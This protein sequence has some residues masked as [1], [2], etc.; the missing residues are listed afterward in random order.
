MTSRPS[1][2]NKVAGF[3]VFP[4][5]VDEKTIE[6][7]SIY[8]LPSV[9]ASESQSDSE[10]DSSDDDDEEEAEE[11]EK[12]GEKEMETRP[13]N[14]KRKISKAFSE[15]S[16]FDMLLEAAEPSVD[17]I[18]RSVIREKLAK[19]IDLETENALIDHF[20]GHE[21]FRRLCSLSTKAF[22]DTCMD[23]YNNRHIKKDDRKAAVCSRWFWRLNAL[24]PGQINEDRKL[25]EEIN[26]DKFSAED[27]HCLVISVNRCIYDLFH[28]NVFT[29]KKD[30]GHDYAGKHETDE[31][32]EEESLDKVYNFAGYALGRM[33]RTREKALSGKGGREVRRDRETIVERELEL[34]RELC[35]DDKS[36]IGLYL[37]VLDRGGLTFPKDELRGFL[38][39]LDKKVRGCISSKLFKLYGKQMLKNAQDNILLD[40]GL[41]LSFVESLQLI[42]SVAASV[43]FGQEI[44]IAIFKDMVNKYLNC[45]AA[46]FR[47]ALEEIE[48]SSSGSV[49]NAT[50]NLRDL[51]KTF[52]VKK[53]RNK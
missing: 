19:V 53:K 18:K 28:A 23:I 29:S 34:V 39:Q 32:I 8:K 30:D 15:F 4:F 45:R 49:V 9:L 35:R 33:K 7:V 10:P 13:S 51:L 46:E 17:D 52:S 1:F 31:E 36:S 3:Q 5:F 2:S 26:N 6:K 22:K 48:L 42:S 47:S 27:V 12:E 16:E 25:I 38:L 24:K 50:Q 43:R 21:Q 37:Q 41:F 11:E 14:G 44:T 40:S 20:F